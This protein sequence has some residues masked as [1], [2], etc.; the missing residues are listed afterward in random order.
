MM[1]SVGKH[2]L[3]LVK[4]FCVKD[5]KQ[6]LKHTRLEDIHLS[7]CSSLEED[8]ETSYVKSITMCK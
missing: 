5:A 1:W 2:N 7:L 3:S 4:Q 6:I 8:H